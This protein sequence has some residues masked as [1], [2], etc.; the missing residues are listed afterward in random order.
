MDMVACL[1]F[2]RGVSVGL[3]LGGREGKGRKG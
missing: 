2:G 3:G 1:D